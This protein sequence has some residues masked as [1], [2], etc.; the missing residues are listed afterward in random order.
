MGPSGAAGDSACQ[1]TDRG[2]WETRQVGGT[3]RPRED[4]TG[5]RPVRESAGHIVVKK[6]GNSRGAKEPYHLQAEC[7]KKGEFDWVTTL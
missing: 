3:Q 2:T 5:R 6:R 4:I 7:K 1:Q